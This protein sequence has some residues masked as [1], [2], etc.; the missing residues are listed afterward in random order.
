MDSAR[1]SGPA[2]GRAAPPAA[3]GFLLG[4]Y[5]YLVAAVALPSQWLFW[6][7]IGFLLAAR[8]GGSDYGH[9]L[10]VPALRAVQALTRPFTDASE[11]TAK[12]LSMLGGALAFAL[13]WR[14]VA[15]GGLRAPLALLVALFAAV[16]PLFWRQL[17]L[18]E[19]TTW[20]AAALLLAAA[21]AEA[22]G[23]RR[24][25]FPL[26]LLT[27]AFALALGLHLVSACAL[28]WLVW[29]ARGPAPA[30]PRRE[31]LVPAGLALLLLALA[32]LVGDPLDR[33]GAFARYWRGFLPREGEPGH[34]ALLATYLGHGAPLLVGATL[35]GLPF[36]AQDARRDA[37]A[38]RE[39]AG[40]LLLGAPYLAAFLA[41]GRPVAG[42]LVPFTLALGLALA[43]GARALDARAPRAT[44]ALGAS[45]LAGQTF[46]A[47]AFALHHATTP[48]QERATALLLAGA[49]PAD[50]L[51]VAGEVAQ[52]VRWLTDAPVVPLPN[53]VHGSWRA[54]ADGGSALERLH[55]RA[56][57]A[58][59]RYGAV[60][61]SSEAADYLTAH[62]GVE[63][64]AL[65]GPDAD[66]IL[67][68]ADP[69]LALFLLARRDEPPAR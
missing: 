56:R 9:A 16:T 30:P 11:H 23:A 6:D 3:R 46:V 63:R 41:F 67:V 68:R 15:R 20:T 8:E 26:A 34:L 60:Y 55:A 48:D 52:H 17:S 2:G 13:L 31:L 38:R 58:L 40:A 21:A 10:Y 64:S 44:Y 53:L 37:V 25:A 18:V 4:F 39:L 19:P 47:T 61:L 45:L 35:V 32:A 65:P 5:L 49:L 62:C 42:L 28:P 43:A 7:D 54:D 50:A 24:G 29:L 59:A 57:E 69:P 33:I 1:E 12:L 36:A 66:T 14:R 22:Y 51:L 27:L